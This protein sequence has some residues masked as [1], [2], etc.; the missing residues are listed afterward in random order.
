MNKIGTIQV[1][2]A[3]AALAVCVAHLH[4]EFAGK[5]AAPDLLP[6]GISYGEIGVNIF[7]VI[8]GFIIVYSSEKLFGQNGGALAFLRRRLIRIVPLYWFSSTI[9]IA[10]SF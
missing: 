1:L 8:S 5:L 10:W 7:F 3:L 6:P 4:Y 2:R 9:L